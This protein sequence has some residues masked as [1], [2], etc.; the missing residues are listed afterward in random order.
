MICTY[1]KPS[2]AIAAYPMI[3]I[4]VDPAYTGKE[5]RYGKTEAGQD[6]L[7]VSQEDYDRRKNNASRMMGM[8]YYDQVQGS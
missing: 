5:Y 8:S 1:T 6:A 7:Y 2:G 3:L 4:L